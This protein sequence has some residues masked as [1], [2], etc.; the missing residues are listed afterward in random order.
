MTARRR[1]RAGR[2]ASSSW[3]AA[4]PRPT[5]VSPDL[6][7]GGRA[8]ARAAPAA[9]PAPAGTRRRRRGRRA[10]ARRGARRA[11]AGGRSRRPPA[12]VRSTASSP[13][14]ASATR[15]GPTSSPTSRRTR[16]K[17]TTWRT[18]A[19][20]IRRLTERP[21]SRGGVDEPRERLVAHALDVLAVLQ[22]RAERLLDDVGVD[23]LPPERVE[24]HRPVDRLGDARRLRQVEAPQLADERRRLGREP[25]RDP[26]DPDLDDLD[27]AVDRRVADPVEERAAL[28]GVV[29]L[30]RAVGGEDHGRLAG[31]RGSCR[32]RGS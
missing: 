9:A 22:H 19:S 8:L 18:T 3:L 15:P 16:P 29:Q 10:R 26:G 25:L 7:P 20:A 11:S 14:R 21:R 28:E 27:L 17:V 31:G 5:G 4:A 2:R 6:L 12:R 24:R 30:A 13:R 32:A 1:A 23:L